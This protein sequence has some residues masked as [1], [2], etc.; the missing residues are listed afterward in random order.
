MSRTLALIFGSIVALAILGAFLVY[1]DPSVGPSKSAGD[2][3]RLSELTLYCA[4]S[5]Q[6]VIEKVL[7]DYRNET[8]RRVVVQYGGSQTLL[9]QIAVTGGGDLYLP[10]DDSYIALA[11]ERGLT[12]EV[13]PIARMQCGLAVQKGNPLQIKTLADLVRKDVHLIQASPEAT[14]VG[15]LTRATLEPMNRWAD[16]EAA[17]I[18]FRT[19]VT[20]VANDVVVGSADAAIVYDAAIDSY[21][22]LEFVAVPELADATSRVVVSVLNSA[23]DSAA[24]LHLARFITAEDRGLKRYEENGFAIDTGDKWADTPELVLYAGSMLRPAIEETI[25][26][27]EQREGVHVSRAYNGCGIL[28]SQM[29]SGQHP[30]AYFACDTAFMRQ[31]SDLFPNSVNVS[32]NELV[33]LVQKGNPKNVRSLSDLTQSG[34][35]I[36][37]GHEKQCAMGWITQN[38]FKEVGLQ[39]SLMDNV[40][41]QTPTGD[42]LVNQMRTGALDAAVVY[43]SNAAGAAET[44]D[45]VRIKNLPC[46]TATQPWAVAEKSA[47]PTLADRLF[48]SICSAKSQDTFLAEGFQWGLEKEAPSE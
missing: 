32:Q 11:A 12:R 43:L 3:A 41:V 38:T 21:D 26:A 6:A 28:V 39:D 35:R 37:I 15:K 8:G 7:E 22:T 5:N 47:Y 19:T 14:A 2:A 17:T 48:Q 25:V 10:A 23:Q 27:F 13:L 46:S 1:S 44:L 4:A 18:A 40:T 16:L 31:V 9:S 24:A 36:G 30:D 33:I 29:Q 45:A 42:M 34:L 20:E